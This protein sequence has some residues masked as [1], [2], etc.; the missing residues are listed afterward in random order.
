MIKIMKCFDFKS[1]MGESVKYKISK[2]GFQR[3]L[4]GGIVFGLGWALSGACPGH[5]YMF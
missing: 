2:Q 3:Y 5:P 1:V 4:F